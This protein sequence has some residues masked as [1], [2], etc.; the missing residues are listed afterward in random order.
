MNKVDLLEMDSADMVDVIHYFFDEDFRYASVEGAHVHG[1][2]RQH[3]FKNLYQKEYK[4]SLKSDN[5]SSTTSSNDGLEVKPYIPPTEF[6]GETGL[7]MG[8]LLDA[9]L[10]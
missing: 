6:D 2:I 7:P 9:P 10:G 4:Y 5:A 1:A 3:I 8:G